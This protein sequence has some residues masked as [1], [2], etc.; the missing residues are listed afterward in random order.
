MILNI[1]GGQCGEGGSQVQ[2]RRLRFVGRSDNFFFG[3]D[4]EGAD[5]RVDPVLY[6]D[7]ESANVKGRMC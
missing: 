7:V 2:Q 5:G 6:G 1:G 4:G 3:L